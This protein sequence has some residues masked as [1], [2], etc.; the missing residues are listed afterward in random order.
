MPSVV[1]KCER[2]TYNSYYSFFLKMCA[3]MQTSCLYGGVELQQKV[4]MFL[5][6][7]PVVTALLH[8]NNGLIFSVFSLVL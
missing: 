2:V 8:S 7:R 4:Q 3:D 1:V 5:S 6:Q